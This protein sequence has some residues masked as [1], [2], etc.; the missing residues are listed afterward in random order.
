MMCI[1][2]AAERRATQGCRSPLSKLNS[3]YHSHTVCHQRLPFPSIVP[4]GAACG[5]WV[6]FSPT[7]GAP[8]PAGGV[9]NG[10]NR[11]GAL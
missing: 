6:P 2:R 3:G 4:A 9:T 8:T 1:Y 5:E 10:R 11:T 7:V